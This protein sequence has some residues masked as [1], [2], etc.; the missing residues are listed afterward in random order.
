MAQNT[1]TDVAA[2]IFAFVRSQPAGNGI[3]VNPVAD[4]HTFL[5]HDVGVA[6]RSVTA[7]QAA[8]VGEGSRSGARA[9]KCSQTSRMTSMFS[10]CPTSTNSNLRV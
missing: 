8:T 10:I 7:D 2:G 9:W 1:P 3:Y 6:K 5:A 4:E